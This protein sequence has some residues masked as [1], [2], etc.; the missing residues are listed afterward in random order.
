MAEDVLAMKNYSVPGYVDIE[1][2]VRNLTPLSHHTLSTENLP[3]ETDG[4]AR[5]PLRRGPTRRKWW[6]ME[7]PDSILSVR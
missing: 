5:L 6:G 4:W 3:E 7:Q 2:G 1:L